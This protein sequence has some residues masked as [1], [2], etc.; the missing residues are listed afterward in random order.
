M[1]AVHIVVLAEISQLSLQ[2]TDIPEEHMVKKFSTNGSN[3]PF[4]EGMR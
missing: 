3:Q 1:C 4:D 2:V